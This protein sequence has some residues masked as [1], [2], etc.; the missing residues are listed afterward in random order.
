MRRAIELTNLAWRPRYDDDFS[1][2]AR[3]ILRNFDTIPVS[4]ALY[5]TAGAPRVKKVAQVAQGLIKALPKPAKSLLKPVNKG[6]KALEK[7]AE[8][9]DTIFTIFAPFILDLSSQGS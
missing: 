7:G 5:R 6:L 4:P 2:M 3:H 9:A 1:F 8:V